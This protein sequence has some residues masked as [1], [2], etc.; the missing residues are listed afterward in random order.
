MQMPGEFIQAA[1]AVVVC[2]DALEQPK[3]ERWNYWLK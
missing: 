3:T 1:A 2:I